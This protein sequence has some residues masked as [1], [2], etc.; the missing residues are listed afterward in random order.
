M[1]DVWAI[2]NIVH[3]SNQRLDTAFCCEL[4]LN[5]PSNENFFS[6][7]TTCA[8]HAKC[9]ASISWSQAFLITVEISSSNERIYSLPCEY[10][11]RSGITDN[12]VWKCVYDFQ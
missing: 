9:I 7:R 2:E 6:I 3:Q 8:A 1:L 11:F 12:T 5:D 10:A 4:C